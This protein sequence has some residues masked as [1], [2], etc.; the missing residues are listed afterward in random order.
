[1]CHMTADTIDELETMARRLSLK[2]SWLQN[3]GNHLHYDI[4]KGNR[5][6]AIRLGAVQVSSRTI[7]RVARQL[8]RDVDSTMRAVDR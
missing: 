2:P 4:C 5:I 3:Q 8:K 6:H 1:M 7:A